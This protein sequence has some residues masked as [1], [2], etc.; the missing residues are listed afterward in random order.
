MLYPSVH[1]INTFMVLI[2]GCH[3]YSFVELILTLWKKLYQYVHQSDLTS[4]YYYDR[5]RKFLAYIK[6]G[7]LSLA[8]SNESV[9]FIILYINNNNK[10]FSDT[11]KCQ[12]Y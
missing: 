10:I 2:T 9:R 5:N 12:S 11:Y 1:T 3:M 8:L 6:F 7:Q 4:P